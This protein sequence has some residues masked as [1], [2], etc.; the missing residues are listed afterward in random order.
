MRDFNE[1]DREK[2][3]MERRVLPENP[4]NLPPEK[5]AELEDRMF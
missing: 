1:V 4:A 5:L 3:R 2:K